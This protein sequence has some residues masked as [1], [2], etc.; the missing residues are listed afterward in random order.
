MRTRYM[1]RFLRKR[2]KIVRFIT[3]GQTKKRTERVTYG[4]RKLAKS[5]MNICE[6]Y[7]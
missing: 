6:I 1:T 4:L 7:L 3:D 2:R 5:T